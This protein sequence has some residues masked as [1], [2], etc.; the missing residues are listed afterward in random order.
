MLPDQLPARRTTLSGLVSGLLA[1]AGAVLGGCSTMPEPT[2]PPHVDHVFVASFLVGDDG[3]LPFLVTSVDVV[4]H[5]L[6]LDPKP[7]E[8]RFA[9]DARWFVYPP[10]TTVKVRGAL[11]AYTP[12]DGAAPDLRDLLNTGAARMISLTTFQANASSTPPH[13]RT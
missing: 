5:R 12:H 1:V 3:K 6:E 7:G 10:G 9:S 11:R 13:E 2:Y 8:E 4:L